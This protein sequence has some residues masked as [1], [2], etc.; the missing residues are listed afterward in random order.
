MTL[1]RLRESFGGLVPEPPGSFF[2]RRFAD[3][4][5]A[6]SW[7]PDAGAKLAMMLRITPVMGAREPGPQGEREISC[8]TIA[9]GMPGDPVNLW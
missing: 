4:E 2:D 1:I 9:Q 3:G 8:K 5:V 7:R 6:W